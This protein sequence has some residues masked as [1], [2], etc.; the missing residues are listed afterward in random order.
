MYPGIA[1]T[2]SPERAAPLSSPSLQHSG[3]PGGKKCGKMLCFKTGKPLAQQKHNC[4]WISHNYISI[5][6]NG[7]KRAQRAL[8]RS[9]DK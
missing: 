7:N 4:P 3:G 5:N 6:H 2:P 9:P 1:M 8:D